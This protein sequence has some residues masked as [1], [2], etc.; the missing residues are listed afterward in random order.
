GAARRR[1]TVAG[2]RLRTL[3][4]ATLILLAVT[5]LVGA[6]GLPWLAGLSLD[7][8]FWLRTAAFGPRYDPAASPTVVGAIHEETYPNARDIFGPRP[9]ET[10]TPELAQVLNALREAGVA[11]IGFDIVLAASVNDIASNYDREYLRALALAARENRIVLGRMQH[12]RDP[13]NPTP[14]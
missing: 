9:K 6:Y 2:V 11:V 12:S 10:W 4:A 1:R 3:A 5:G 8:A 14:A 7:V 13:I